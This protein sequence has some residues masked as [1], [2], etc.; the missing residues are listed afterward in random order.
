[1]LTIDDEVMLYWDGT[2]YYSAIGDNLW[3]PLLE[4]AWAKMK[5]TYQH[6]SGGWA[7]NGIR[8]FTGAPT[9]EYWVK[10]ITTDAPTT[11]DMIKAADDLNYIMGAGTDGSDSDLNSCN[12]VAGHAFSMIAAFKLMTG[13][14]VDHKLYMLRNPWGSTE[15]NGKWNKADTAWTSDYIS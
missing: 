6:A 13:S 9:F 4:K 1:M 15:Y 8:A 7:Q 10:D 14:T 3:V 12:I 11:F 5:G 2:P